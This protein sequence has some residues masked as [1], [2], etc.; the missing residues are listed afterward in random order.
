MSNRSN[1]NDGGDLDNWD[2]IRWRGAVAS[3]IRG[4][5]G[6]KLLRE[7]LEALDSM[8]EKRLAADTLTRADGDHCTL[9]VVLA[10]RGVDTE[11]L[12]AQLGEHDFEFGYDDPDAVETFCDS[13][14][15]ELGV[16]PALV[17]EIMFLNDS[18]DCVYAQLPTSRHY[19]PRDD[20]ARVRWRYMRNWVAVHLQVAA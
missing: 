7:L 15:G 20:P 13:I 14:A 2:L 19:G 5:R 12:Q 3:A 16:A 18:V 6:Q 10:R 9:G 1:Y 11:P 8:P 17:R 4:K